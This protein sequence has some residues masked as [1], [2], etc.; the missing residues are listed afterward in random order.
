[1]RKQ[2]KLLKHHSHFLTQLI[3]LLEIMHGGNALDDDI[4]LG[5]HLQQVDAAQKGGFAAAGR[6]DHTYAF[7]AADM[8]S[9]SLEHFKLAE[10]FVKILYVNHSYASTFPR[11]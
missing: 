7:A 10:I 2:V 1:M 5:R 9:Y 11:R 4:P 6:S 8:G 3:D